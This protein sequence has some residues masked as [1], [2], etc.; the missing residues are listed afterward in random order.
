M[1]STIKVA[2][3]ALLCLILTM[4]VLGVPGATPAAADA[5]SGELTSA[6]IVAAFNA[7]RTGN[8]L[9]PVVENADWSYKCYLHDRW[10]AA[11]NQLSHAET[12]GTPEYSE[13]G[14]WAG[15]H[16]VLASGA[17]WRDAD[18]WRTAPIHLSQMMSPDLRSVGAAEFGGY[19]C[20]TTWPGY[21]TSA[22]PPGTFTWFPGNGTIL[23]A[24][25]TAFE[26]PTV[27]QVWVGIPEGTATGPHLYLYY[28]DGGTGWQTPTT[29]T[30]TTV[31]L[32]GPA[33]PVEVRVVTRAVA[34]AAGYGGYMPTLAVFIP[35]NPLAPDSSYT[36]AVNTDQGATTLS[37]RTAAADPSDEPAA[38][39]PQRI[40]G[41]P[42]KLRTSRIFQL[43]R[44]TNRGQRIRWRSL[45]N[46]V[47]RVSGNRLITRRAR[48]ICTLRARAP[49]NDTAQALAVTFRI[50]IIRR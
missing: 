36:L 49:G 39:R 21:D 33:G 15:T 29:P 6:Q 42:A 3:S 19:S 37:F 43:P 30:I 46:R 12:P 16:S 20:L 9:P 1:E 18:P 13:G 50:R 27:P 2:A 44:A 47:C 26:L 41:M 32:T 34:E 24:S 11:N 22:T 28:A 5:R 23:P 25:E 38:R 4:A 31:A 17:T 48:G 45:S 10:M 7:E 40:R 8:G 14:N 35:R